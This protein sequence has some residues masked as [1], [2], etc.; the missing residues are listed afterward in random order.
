MNRNMG[1]LNNI[2]TDKLVFGACITSQHPL[3]PGAMES[4]GFDFVFIDPEHIPISRN[5]G[6]NTIIHSSDV[7]I[8]SQKLRQDLQVIKASAGIAQDSANTSSGP[9]I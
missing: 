8:F 9:T 4:A 2:K 5:E 7:A 3:W 1:F 6:V